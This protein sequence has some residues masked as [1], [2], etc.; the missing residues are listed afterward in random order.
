MPSS[1]RR[2]FLGAS[3]AVG[4][5]SLVGFNRVQAQNSD[6]SPTTRETDDADSLGKWDSLDRWLASANDPQRHQIRDFRYDDPP[7]VYLGVSNT[8][9]FSPPAIKVTPGTTVTW[10]WVGDN[11]E[12][13]VVAAD[14]TF[15]S[16]YPISKAGNTFEYKFETEGTYKYVSEPHES[17]GMKGVVVVATAPSSGYPTVDEW[18]A[19][20]NE[21]DGTITDQTGTDLV[22]ISTGAKGNGGNFAFD[23]HAVKISTGTTVRWKWLGK[24]GGHNLAFKGHDIGDESIYAKSGIHFEETFTESG[25]YPYSCEPHHSIGH[26]GAVIVE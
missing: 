10:E 9:S 13:N 26:R 14:G 15:D 18:L 7:T 19:G 4:L 23:P 12:H 22:E 25:I 3:V 2:T 11:A 8:K 1:N 6:E 17:A 20:T 16:G 5:G 24:G 21:Y